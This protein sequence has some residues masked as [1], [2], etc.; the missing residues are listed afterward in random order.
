MIRILQLLING[1]A[2][3]QKLHTR[4]LCFLRTFTR[5]RRQLRV[6]R[7][8][9]KNIFEPI[10][11]K[12]YVPAG[13]QE[14]YKQSFSAPSVAVKSKSWKT[15]HG[16]HQPYFLRL[17]V[18]VSAVFFESVPRVIFAKSLACE[19]FF[20]SGWQRAVVEPFRLRKKIAITQHK[21]QLCSRDRSSI[22]RR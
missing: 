10:F 16:S 4:S 9:L 2:K 5:T 19:P 13:K 18:A 14:R 1:I 20:M 21:K 15:R 3:H 11:F 8:C 7:C 12:P 17:A 6:F 22:V